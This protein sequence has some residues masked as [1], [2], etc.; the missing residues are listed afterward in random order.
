MTDQE[1]MQMRQR[2]GELEA[3]S[4]QLAAMFQAEFNQIQLQLLSHV[5]AVQRS[6]D[7]AVE[8]YKSM[9]AA[10]RR[11]SEIMSSISDCYG[12]IAEEM[13]TAMGKSE[14]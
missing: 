9:Q 2:L 11:S 3:T 10:T 4:I 1:Q 12:V 7:K 14:A 13:A 8:V 6:P 5:M